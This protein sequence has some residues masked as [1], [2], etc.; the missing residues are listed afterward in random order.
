MPTSDDA[1]QQDYGL[2]ILRIIIGVVFLAHGYLKLFGMGIGGVTGFFGHL[3]IP[4]PA[5]FAWVIS[6]L[7]TFGGIALILGVFTRIVGLGL[8]ADMAGAIFF[9]KAHGAFFAPKGSELEL[10]LLVASLALALT[11]PGAFAL[12]EF[13]GRPRTASP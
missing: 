8:A 2:L 3:G 6:L 1:R 7:E 13:I 10:T 11:G 4:A 5:L 9:A 12:R